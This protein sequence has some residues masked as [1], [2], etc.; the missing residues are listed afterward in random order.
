[1]SASQP[2]NFLAQKAL[3]AAALLTQAQERGGI[4]VVIEFE[5][6]LEEREVRPDDESINRVKESIRLRQN[7]IL[8]RHFGDPNNPRPAP[9]FERSLKRGTISPFFAINVTAVELEQLASDS[10]VSR[11][12]LDRAYYLKLFNSVPMIGMNYPNGG[13][14]AGGATGAG[15]VIAIVDSGVQKDHPFITSTTVI[16]EACFSTTSSIDNST[17]LCP[18]GTQRQIG[19]GSGANCSTSDDCFHGTH[20]AGIAAGFNTSANSPGGGPPNG[21]AKDARLVAVQAFSAS[22]D[23]N[24]CTGFGNIPCIISHVSDQVLALDWL[25]EES[26]TFG[27]LASV[28]MSLGSRQLFYT[29]CAGDQDV[30]LFKNSVARLRSI[31]V[32]TILATG[33]ESAM[34]AIAKP[35]CVSNTVRVFS[36]TKDDHISIFS[37]CLL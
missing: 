28:N 35:A 7:E 24:T 34:S 10:E 13:A 2:S 26:A 16:A 32:A 36:T 19:P 1:M 25:Y 31:Q 4:R 33:N 14:Y 27:S 8:A 23:L 12:N 22:S 6:T 9:G 37:I 21:V 11:I 17:T 15:Q 3:D 20:V 18:D 30:Q 29:N 5:P